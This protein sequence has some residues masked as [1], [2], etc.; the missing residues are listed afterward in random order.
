MHKLFIKQRDEKVVNGK[1]IVSTINVPHP[2]YQRVA[3]MIEQFNQLLC[4]D[5]VIE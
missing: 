2:I 3:E 4:N 1:L 5:V